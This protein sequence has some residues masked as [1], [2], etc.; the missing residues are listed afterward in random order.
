[1]TYLYAWSDPEVP[2]I[3][4][5]RRLARQE[6][7]VV[8]DDHVLRVFQ[9]EVRRQC[10]FA[11]IAL[12][13]LDR[14]LRRN[15]GDR[16]FFSIQAC[17]AAIANLSKLLWPSENQKVRLPDRGPELR[18]SLDIDEKSPLRDRTFRN[19]FEH[20]DERLEK[21]AATSETRNIVEA[22]IGPYTSVGGVAPEDRMRSFDPEKMELVVRGELY[23]FKPV[24][25]ALTALCE[26]VDEIKSATFGQSAGAGPGPTYFSQEIRLPDLVYELNANPLRDLTF[27]HCQLLGP[28]I[29]APTG[30]TFRPLSVDDYGHP[31]ALFWE[32]PGES[33][34]GPIAAENCVFEDS[35]FVGVGFTGPPHILETLRKAI[36]PPVG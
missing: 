1:M 36:L 5:T 18:K 28:A 21:W 19:H 27:R 3:P 33:G 10:S 24:L 4:G 32:I 35:K 15:D 13:D 30:C 8:M 25:S 14:A 12:A 6:G 34:I 16:V 20:F 23:E 31:E 22:L 26:R 11:K 17:L 2:V 29:L 9:S 7:E